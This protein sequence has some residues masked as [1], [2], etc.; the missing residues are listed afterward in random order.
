[1]GVGFGCS[2]HDENI[3]ITVALGCVLN[4]MTPGIWYDAYSSPR[5][6][7]A[8]DAIREAEVTPGIRPYARCHLSGFM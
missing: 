2:C 5:G 6:V 7:E 1:M 8:T 3:V 4:T